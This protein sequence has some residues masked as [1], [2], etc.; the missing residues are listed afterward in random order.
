MSIQ[1]NRLKKVNST[2]DAVTNDLAATAR[3]LEASMN[4]MLASGQVGNATVDVALARANIERLMVESG[5][6]EVTGDLLSTKYQGFIDGAHAAYEKQLGKS[7]QYSDVSLSR[8]DQIRN[9][10]A[11]NFNTIAADNINQLQKV[12]LDYQFGAMDLRAASDRI[13]KIM[14]P[15]FERYADTVIR[16]TAVAF[17]R[18]ANNLMAV[19]AGFTE[20]EYI[21]PDDSVTRDF[22]QEQLAKGPMPWS[23]W[24]KLQNEGGYPAAIYGGGVNCRHQIVPTGE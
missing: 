3:K 13:A 1:L 11:D 6:Y 21:G 16:E 18:E 5:Y 20:F 9:L 23:Y 22:C 2:I 17:D 4:Q 19:D 14:G 8:L 7:L 24:Q 15:D 10:D 12:M